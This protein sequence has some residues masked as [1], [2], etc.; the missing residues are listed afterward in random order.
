MVEFGS[1]YKC[2]DADCAHASL[3]KFSQRNFFSYP[4]HLTL[5]LIILL[6]Q[7]S[8]A[9]IRPESRI[10][11][12]VCNRNEG[13]CEYRAS[14]TC[15]PNLRHGRLARDLFHYNPRLNR[16]FRMGFTDNCNAFLS[17]RACLMYCVRPRG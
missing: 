1:F 14:C 7:G 9:S 13:L 8:C 2:H 17:I 4:L 15:N 3:R 5:V 6:L 16:C 10:D 12:L 11:E